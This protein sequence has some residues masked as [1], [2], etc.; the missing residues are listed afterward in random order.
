MSITWLWLVEKLTNAGGIYSDR[1]TLVKD[2]KCQKQRVS[3][4]TGEKSKRERERE[5][6]EERERKLMGV[7]WL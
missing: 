2:K 6:K 3:I 5:R 1:S 4:R 7:G